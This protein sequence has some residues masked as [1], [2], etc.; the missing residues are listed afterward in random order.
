[1]NEIDT[2][3]NLRTAFTCYRSR[4]RKWWKP[5]FYWLLDTCKINAYL[6]WKAKNESSNH[7][8]FFDILVDELLTIPLELEFPPVNPLRPVYTLEYL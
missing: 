2:V 1:M 5:L 3:N 8:K 7:T 6:V 4:N